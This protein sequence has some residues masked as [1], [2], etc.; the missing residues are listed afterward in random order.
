VNIGACAAEKDGCFE[1]LSTAKA[2]CSLRD[3]DDL[4][5]DVFWDGVGDPVSAVSY[6]FANTVDLRG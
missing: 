5:V 3:G 2:A 1:V 4:A 6:I